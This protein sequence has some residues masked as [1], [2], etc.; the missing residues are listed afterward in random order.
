MRKRRLGGRGPFEVHRGSP[1]RFVRHSV[2]TALYAASLVCRRAE[3]VPALTDEEPTMKQQFTRRQFVQSSA[4]L[5]ALAANPYWLTSR[6]RAAESKN[7]R[8]LVG[9]IGLGGQ[10][11]GIARRASGHGDVVAVW[12]CSTTV[13]SS[14]FPRCIIS[15]A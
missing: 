1:R 2:L 3:K 6:A 10:G 8:P 12:A 9:S 15:A 14:T 5:A 11:T 4:G 7:E 13:P